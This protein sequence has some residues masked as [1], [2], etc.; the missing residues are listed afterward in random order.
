MIDSGLSKG[1][2][3]AS[4]HIFA[5]NIYNFTVWD[6]RGYQ[7]ILRLPRVCL[8]RQ[9]VPAATISFQ[10]PSPILARPL[11]LPSALPVRYFGRGVGRRW[12][13]CDHSPSSRLAF[14]Q[15]LVV[16]SGNAQSARRSCSSSQPVALLTT[17]EE[18]VEK[19]WIGRGRRSRS[20]WEDWV[21]EK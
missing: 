11:A 13:A 17:T 12:R 4:C 6:F 18:L 19:N 20:C 1:K 7:L 9:F 2:P 21:N 16:S 3:A 5:V 14:D 10:H 8:A 15:A